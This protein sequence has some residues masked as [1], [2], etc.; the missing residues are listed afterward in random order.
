MT[1][2]K[3]SSL[4]A[5]LKEKREAMGLSLEDISEVTKI[6]VKHLAALERDAF[7]ELPG[8]YEWFFLRTYAKHLGFEVGEIRTRYDE[9]RHP[10]TAVSEAPASPA[11]FANE[12]RP[13]NE[14]P[15]L[16]RSTV[17]GHQ[18]PVPPRPPLSWPLMS[19]PAHPSF[20]WPQGSRAWWWGGAVLC[21]LG[22]AWAI[23]Q[24]PVKDRVTFQPTQGVR[25]DESEARLASPAQPGEREA[26]QGLPGLSLQST[27]RP[28]AQVPQE[29]L[30]HVKAKAPT[31]F[32]ITVDGQ[33]RFSLNMRPGEERT[34]LAH[35]SF[36]VW[37]GSPLG[38]DLTLNQQPLVLQSAQGGSLRDVEIFPDGRV[39]YHHSAVEGP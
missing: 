12:A 38:L 15:R 3:N 32:E 16:E 13:A 21:A 29:A 33:D 36:R 14:A 8:G 6:I 2:G 34:W 22:L 4:G 19:R 27:P 20:Q 31:W 37:I 18:P 9:F 10:K 5:R 7:Q 23:H 26:V 25:S 11:R 24:M 30:L 35:R 1:E 39:E 28:A 17:S